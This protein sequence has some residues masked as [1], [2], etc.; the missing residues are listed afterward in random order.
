MAISFFLS[1]RN[2]SDPGARISEADMRRFVEILRTTPALQDACIYAPDSA[3]DPYLNDGPAP[4]F[5]AELYFARIEEL[6]SAV[7]ENGH[8]QALAAPGAFPSLSGAAVTQQAM[9]NRAFPVPEPGSG[10]APGAPR[11]TYLVSYEGSADDLNAWLHHYIARHPPIMARFPGIRAIEVCTRIDWCGSLPWP[12]V[13][14][15]LRNKVVFD[16]AAALTAA[17]NSPVRHE[18]RADYKAFPSFCGP[19]SH[20]PMATFGV[21][22]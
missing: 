2:P 13:D 4:Q 22:T 6:E 7:E 20:Y 18:M 15:M 8:L 19:V 3:S 9:L 14:Y 12:R 11:C 5:A 17:L 16:S 21:L 1:F 10:I